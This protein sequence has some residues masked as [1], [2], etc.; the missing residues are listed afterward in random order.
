MI[1]R[2]I[3]SSIIPYG[4]SSQI[5]KVQ[6]CEA[7]QIALIAKGS[8]KKDQPL[9][10]LWEYEFNLLAPKEEGLYLLKEAAELRDYSSYPS[11]STWAAADCGVELLTQV[12]ISGPESEAY[13]TLLTNYLGYLQGV[14]KNAVL[15]LWRLF[16]RLYQMLGLDVDLRKCAICKAT[17]EMQAHTRSAELICKAC[18]NDAGWEMQPFNPRSV[19]I[20]WLLPEIGNHLNRV[21]VDRAVVQEVNGFWLDYFYAHHKKTLKLKSLSVLCQFYPEF[22]KARSY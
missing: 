12:I 8:R 15:L 1:T 16:L 5:C 6:S 11:T 4:E 22:K 19:E 14:D 3:I 21:E 20:I 13:Y 17:G 9:L 10:R 7:G 2:G 18:V